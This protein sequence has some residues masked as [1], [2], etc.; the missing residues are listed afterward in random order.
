VYG[1]EGTTV[2]P[3]LPKSKKGIR[4]MPNAENA[5]SQAAGFSENHLY[6]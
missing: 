2:V 4:K 5:P 3:P 1:K 6:L